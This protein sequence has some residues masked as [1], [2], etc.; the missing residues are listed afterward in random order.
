MSPDQPNPASFTPAPEPPNKKGNGLMA[1][2]AA[3]ALRV[4]GA[5]KP[6]EDDPHS[7]RGLRK[8]KKNRVRVGGRAF[9]V[10]NLVLHKEPAPPTN[11]RSYRQ[12]SR[13][14]RKRERQRDAAFALLYEF[15]PEFR[16]AYDAEA[17]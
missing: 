9:E 1:M 8:L 7:A 12:M 11:E 5:F 4:S 17:A 16:E 2:M 14:R 6:R 13:N 15:D 3:L 10:A